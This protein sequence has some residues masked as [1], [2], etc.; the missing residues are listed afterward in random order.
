M[1]VWHIASD[2]TLF[3]LLFVHVFMSFLWC[4][5]MDKYPAA[6]L[7]S[8]QRSSRLKK[9]VCVCTMCF[10]VYVPGPKSTFSQ[11]CSHKRWFGSEHYRFWR[12]KKDTASWYCMTM[13]H[14]GVFFSFGETL[15]LSLRI[16]L[17]ITILFLHSFLWLILY[18]L[19]YFWFIFFCAFYLIILFYAFFVYSSSF[20]HL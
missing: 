15:F 6:A 3:A 16:A 12:D 5:V 11:A 1:R 18:G 4:R 8:K 13:M 2:F 19:L 9:C 17:D 7:Q 10:P 20:R 14:T